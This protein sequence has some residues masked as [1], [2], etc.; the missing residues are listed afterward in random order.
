MIGLLVVAVLIGI[1]VWVA[2][3]GFPEK[4]KQGFIAIALVLIVVWL[5]WFIGVPFADLNQP[6]GGK[7]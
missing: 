4:I 3:A 7:S 6:L 5:L 2:P 1:G